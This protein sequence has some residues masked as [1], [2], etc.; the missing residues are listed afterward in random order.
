MAIKPRGISLSG[1]TVAS[2]QSV[3]AILGKALLSVLLAAD[4]K[5]IAYDPATP[6]SH[7]S[8]SIDFEKWPKRLNEAD[9]IVVTCALT[10]SSQHMI[11][12]ESI[13]MTKKGVRIVNVGRGPI[14]EENALIEA[15]ESGQVYSAALDVFEIEPLPMNSPLR[16]HPK[17]IFGSHN[18]SN[19]VDAVQH[20]SEIA[21]DKLFAFLGITEIIK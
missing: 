21:I 8:S 12:S 20:T 11:N 13:A 1:I 3:L 9:Y 18:A 7:S 14:I 2:P 19:T 4:M 6:E 5:V 17:C 15:L 10:P 16:K